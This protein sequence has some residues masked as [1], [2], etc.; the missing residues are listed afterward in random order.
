[1]WFQNDKPNNTRSAQKQVAEPKDKLL[2]C[3]DQQLTSDQ[4]AVSASVLETLKAELKSYSEVVKGS[5]DP[6]ISSEATKRIFSL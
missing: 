3:K 1:M 5:S 2:V 6:S 4:T